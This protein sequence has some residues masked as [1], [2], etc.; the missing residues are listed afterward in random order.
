MKISELADQVRGISL[1]HVLEHYGFDL[2][3]EGT[4]LRARGAHHNIVVTGYR[5]FDNKAGIGGGGAID[6]VIHLTKVGFAR[7]ADP[8]LTGFFRSQRGQ[9]ALSFPKSWQ[10]F[11]HP[12]KKSFEE[13]AALYAARVDSNWPTARA[14]LVEKRKI[15]PSTGGRDA[16]SR[17][18]L[19][20]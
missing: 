7:P 9:R 5:W 16:C 6:L 10:E 20:E 19:R 2:K 18:D 15:S 8:W 13:L 1:R 4:T 11:P 12:K 14:Y 17:F 3:R